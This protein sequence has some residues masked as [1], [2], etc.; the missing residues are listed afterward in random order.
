MDDDRLAL[1]LMA[2]IMI[3]IVIIIPIVAMTII[4]HSWSGGIEQKSESG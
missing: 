4:G 1:V 2:A 3:V